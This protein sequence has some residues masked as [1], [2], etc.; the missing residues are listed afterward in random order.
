MAEFRMPSLGA[1]ME[2]G[3]LVQWLKHP[4]DAVRRGDIIAVVD[5]QKGAIEVEVF[6]DGIVRQHLVQP[7]EKV[8]VGAILALIDGVG[9]PAAPPPAVAPPAPPPSR[10]RASPAAR[11]LAEER[12]IDLTTVKGTGPDGAIERVDIERAPAARVAGARAGA[13][14]GMRAAIGAAMARSKREIPHFY[15][16]AAIDLTNALGWLARANESRPVTGRLLPV[17]MLLKGVASGLGEAPEMNGFWGAGGFEPGP[18]IHIG[19]AIAVRGGG[20]V[21]P[22]LHDVDRKDVDVVMREL[23]DL[24]TRTRAGTLRSSELTDATITVTSLG[25]G[26]ADA[27]FGV[28]YPPQVAIVGF[29]RIARRPW[30]VDER[31]EVRSIV[32]ASVSVDHRATDGH[33]AARFLARLDRVL[34]DPEALSRDQR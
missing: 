24:I 11:R 9:A 23:A 2:A 33:R 21:A 31:V 7:G 15:L 34:Q 6:E 17:V 32:T 16:S 5:T 29:G 27:A 19:C 1:D 22:A 8:P 12:G 10:P 18:G 3:T 14:E 25:E 26:G 4:G 20:L 28:I 13:A 30:V